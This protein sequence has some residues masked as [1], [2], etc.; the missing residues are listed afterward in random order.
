MAKKSD[1]RPS[2]DDVG[3]INL[4]KKPNED[5]FCKYGRIE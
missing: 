5:L 4:I 2:L 3:K 1:V